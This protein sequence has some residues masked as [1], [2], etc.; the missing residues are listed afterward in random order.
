[1]FVYPCAVPNSIHGAMSKHTA[2]MIY[3][4]PPNECVPVLDVNILHTKVRGGVLCSV[5]SHE[6]GGGDA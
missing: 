3:I 4:K 5:G 6:E 2:H 1:M